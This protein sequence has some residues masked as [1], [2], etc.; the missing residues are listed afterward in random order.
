[1][2]DN[3]S[4]SNGEVGIGG[5]AAAE[6][7]TMRR[8]RPGGAAVGAS[9]MQAAAAAAGVDMEGRTS[10]NRGEREG[11]RE[12]QRSRRRAQA[13]STWLPQISSTWCVALLLSL[14]F[15]PFDSLLSLFPSQ[16][17]LPVVV[18]SPPEGVPPGDDAAVPSP[19]ADFSAPAAAADFSSAAA[20]GAAGDNEG[21]AAATAA[22]AVALPST[23][24]AAA[25]GRSVEEVLSQDEE[26]KTESSVGDTRR[27]VSL[28]QHLHDLLLVPHNPLPRGVLPHQVTVQLCVS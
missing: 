17:A 20:A 13:A 23:V 24:V 19:A 26:H 28:L 7:A 22:A 1:M 2:G 12:Q 14:F 9:S 10:E 15:L 11:D 6:A 18:Q 4:S 5:D 25:D 21:I 27:G 16:Q 8:A 3:E